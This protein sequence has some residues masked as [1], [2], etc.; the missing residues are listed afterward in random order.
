MDMVAALGSLCHRATSDCLLSLPVGAT[1]GRAVTSPRPTRTQLGA[2]WP[3]LCPHPG[4]PISGWSI[5]CTWHTRPNLTQCLAACTPEAPSGHM[6][7]GS[8]KSTPRQALG[9]VSAWPFP[10]PQA[11]EGS[12]MSRGTPLP[13]GAG[14][15]AG[16]A[17]SQGLS[18]LYW[19]CW[20]SCPTQALHPRVHLA[21][22]LRRGEEPQAVGM[23]AWREGGEAPSRAQSGDT[24]PAGLQDITTCATSTVTLC[25]PWHKVPRVPSNQ[26]LQEL[27]DKKVPEHETPPSLPGSSPSANR[28]VQQA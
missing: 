21:G 27:V 4:L 10:S 3:A 5:S 18:C 2:A 28:C 6:L 20:P 12:D 22:G 16:L 1:T 17:F 7:E 14:S 25:K 24:G 11:T 8:P 19:P 9:E 13:A 23:P 15:P 26:G